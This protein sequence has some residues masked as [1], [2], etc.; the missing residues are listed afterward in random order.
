MVAG[1]CFRL[2]KKDTGASA[3]R[4]ENQY[5]SSSTKKKKTSVS[6]RSQGRG[7]SY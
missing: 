1:H 5:S 6:Y 3:T 4:K 7:R 2:V